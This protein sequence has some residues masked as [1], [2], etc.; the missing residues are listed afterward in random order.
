[1]YSRS[2]KGGDKGHPNRNPWL[3][4]MDYTMTINYQD[5]NISFPNTRLFIILKVRLYHDH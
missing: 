1:M 5:I 3:A 2:A 4:K